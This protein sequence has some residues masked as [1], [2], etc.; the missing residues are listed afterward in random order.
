MGDVKVSIRCV[1]YVLTIRRLS[2][3]LGHTRCDSGGHPRCFD[4]KQRLFADSIC[5]IPLELSNFTQPEL[6]ALESVIGRTP[7]RA[8][9]QHAYPW[10]DVF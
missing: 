1:L 7:N 4:P 3:K 6:I 5:D 9:A 2:E 10:A 8:T